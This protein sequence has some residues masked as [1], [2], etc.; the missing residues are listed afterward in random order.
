MPL[1]AITWWLAWAG[2]VRIYQPLSG[3]HRPSVINPQLANFE[4]VR[5]TVR[6]IPE[7][8]LNAQEASL[9]CQRVQTLFENQGASVSTATAAHGGLQDT[10]T[11]DE[12]D[13]ASA[14]EPAEDEPAEDEPASTQADPTELTLELRARQLHESNNLLSWVLCLGTFTALPG[15]TESTFAQ[16][17]IIRDE[18][19]SLLVSD[20]LEGRLILRFGAGPWVVNKL[21]D[22][23]VRDDED[24]LTGEVASHDL[25]NDL[26][27]QLSQMLFNAKMQAQ[28]LHQVPSGR[29]N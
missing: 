27:R 18:T 19:G 22:L 24:K 28:V 11:S 7:G 4:D 6:C 9:L 25:S 3:L 17:I 10:G 16:D 20:S 26:Y 12:G 15:I 2:C 14:P 21:M 13:D 23:T 29:A 1:A 8:L 5:L